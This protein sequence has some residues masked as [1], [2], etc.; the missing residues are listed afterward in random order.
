MKSLFKIFMLAFILMPAMT[1]VS[2]AQDSTQTEVNKKNLSAASGKTK[3]LLTG[4]GWFGFAYDND[5]KFNF[6]SY[7]FAPVFLWKISDKLF[8]ESE[9]EAPNGEFELEFAKL[10]YAVNN[11]ISIGAG[12]MLTPFG[13]YGEKWEPA[14]IERFPNNPIIPDEDFLPGGTHLNWGAIMGLDVRG[15]VPLGNSR[16]SYVVFVSN[17]PALDNSNGLIDYEN[18]DDNNAN[19][20]VGGRIGLLPFSNSCLELG[21]SYEKGIAG[22]PEDSVYQ[23]NSEWKDYSKVGASAMAVDLNFVKSIPKIKSIIGVKGQFSSYMVDDAYYSVPEG[24]TATNYAPGDSTLYTFN[25]TL[26][27]YYAQ[28]SFRPALLKNKCLKN[29]ELL[30]RYNSLTEPKDAAWS[31]KDNNGAGGVV[32]RMDIGLCYW[33]NWRTGLRFAYESTTHVNGEQ[34]SELLAR[35]VMGF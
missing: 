23:I 3:M 35:F 2:S 26:Q 19:K 6:N 7:G 27:N 1:F 31:E 33:L 10:N 9:I 12:R 5:A 34:S 29:V 24:F 32:T 13:A 22:N 21:F 18:L 11:Y 8:F 28:F 14:F 20:Q 15:R 30:F 25:N 4:A 16:L 17:G